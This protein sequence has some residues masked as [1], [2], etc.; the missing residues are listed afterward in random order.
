[1]IASSSPTFSLNLE[2]I[3]VLLG[4]LISVTILLNILIGFTNKINFLEN[5]LQHL[6]QE[7]IEH[8]NLEGHKI[9]IDKLF[10]SVE[11]LHRVE[12]SLNLHIQDYLNKKD[13]TQ[14][15]LG[16]TNEKIDHKFGRLYNSMK[17]M[18]RFLQ[19]YE[20]FRVKEY[21]DDSDKRFQ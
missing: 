17:D 14:Y 19:K 15:M 10:H 11:D 3:G 13:V 21:L 5:K 16:Q 18:E 9:V 8:S 6:Q 20:D 4:I 12:N 1:M 2:T 7:L